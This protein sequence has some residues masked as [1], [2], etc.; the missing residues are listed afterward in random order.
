MGLMLGFKSKVKTLRET[1]MAGVTNTGNVTA[2]VGNKL[3]LNWHGTPTQRDGVL[4]MF[5]S[6]RDKMMPDLELGRCADGIIATILDDGMS[7][8]DHGSNIQSIAMLWRV[9]T[10]RLDGGT[11]GDLIAHTNMHAAFELHEQINDQFN[12][13][14]KIS[15]MRGRKPKASPDA[16]SDQDHP[17]RPADARDD[18]RSVGASNARPVSSA[19]GLGAK[20]M[21]SEFEGVPVSRLV[22]MRHELTA[23][24]K[25]NLYGG[26]SKSEGQAAVIARNTLDDFVFRMTDDMFVK[27]KSADLAP[28]KRAI[29]LETY[30]ELL[31][32]LEDYSRRFGHGG[33]A[34]KQGMSTI[35]SDPDV[36][37]RFNRDDQTKIQA[38]TAGSSLFA[39]RR[40]NQLHLSIRTEAGRYV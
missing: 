16:T 8:D 22:D 2:T 40:F 37:G 4:Q 25:Q 26:G 38:I 6:I 23:L 1:F 7:P 31:A 30:S 11:Y 19:R 34:I 35:I 39:K 28:L 10:T 12:I 15:V 29:V 13:T 36:F 21:P 17:T 14:W 20:T 3:V 9:F 24:I 27:G 33:N 5:P 18:R 32:I